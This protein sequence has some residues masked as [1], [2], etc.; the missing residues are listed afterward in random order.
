MKVS[1]LD[2]LASV[3][4]PR[5]ADRLIKRAQEAAV[6]FAE[7]RYGDAQ[8]L[9]GPI[10]RELP[11]APVIRELYGLTLYR[12]GRW[13]DAIAELEAFVELTGGSTE[14][15]PVLA[16]CHRALGHWDRVQA[17]W[18]ELKEA[19]PNPWLVAE[20]RIVMAGALA[21]RGELTDAIGV[22]RS[23]WRIPRRPRPDHLRRA[24]ALADLL[25]RAG[26]VPAAR[27][28]FEWVVEVDPT[29]ADAAE[30]RSAAGR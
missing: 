2:E 13:K 28:L 26:D 3:A 7:E 19:S 16:D 6:H 21:D 30:R 5:R 25:E 1:G 29:F 4:D 11:T 27:R 10:A 20:G 9:L 15:H 22:L 8:R 18:D 24:Y 23:G 14:Q 17:L 12:L